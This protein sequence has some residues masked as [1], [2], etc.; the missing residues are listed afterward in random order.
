LASTHHHKQRNQNDVKFFHIYSFL[1]FK[2]EFSSGITGNLIDFQDRDES[3]YQNLKINAWD[4][5]ESVK[6]ANSTW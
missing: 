5:D 3:F 6:N 1:L 4:K 2:Y